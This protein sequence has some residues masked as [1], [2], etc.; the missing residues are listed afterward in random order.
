[1]A[2]SQFLRG[3]WD[4]PWEGMSEPSRLY[5]QHFGNL[6]SDDVYP[7]QR[8][9]RPM[10]MMVPRRPP[11][12]TG[13]SEV[14]QILGSAQSYKVLVLSLLFF[15]R[16]MTFNMLCHCWGLCISK[17][18]TNSKN[19]TTPYTRTHCQ[20]FTRFFPVSDWATCVFT[21]T[22]GKPDQHS[23]SHHRGAGPKLILVGGGGGGRNWSR[24]FA[25][26]SWIIVCVRLF[27]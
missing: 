15:L 23:P 18:K 3:F 12:Q 27:F 19:E 17:K 6:L 4:E 9:G 7:P 13:K 14:S 20:L 22:W 2:L 21:V 5:D 25:C 8:L 26:I 24:Y 11:Q 10:Y 16:K 1:M